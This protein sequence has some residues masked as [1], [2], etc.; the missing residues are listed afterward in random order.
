MPAETLAGLQVTEIPFH[1]EFNPDIPFT[2]APPV[3]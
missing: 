2:R 3:D 1:Q